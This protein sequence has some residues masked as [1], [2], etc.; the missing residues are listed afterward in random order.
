MAAEKTLEMNEH[1]MRRVRLYVIV[2]AATLVLLLWGRDLLTAAQRLKDREQIDVAKSLAG[3]VVTA[4]G[5]IVLVLLNLGR[6]WD[7]HNL[8]DR[9]IFGIRDKTDRVI[10]TQMI[11]AAQDVGAPALQRMESDPKGVRYVFYHF[12]NEQETLRALAFTYWEQY[13]V[14]LYNIVLCGLGLVISATVAV[15][16]Q[17]SWLGFA[18]PTIFLLVGAFTLLSTFRSLAH[19]IYDLPVQQVAEIRHSKQDE[20]VQE[21]E[22]RFGFR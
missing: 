3:P 10:Q 19:K 6:D 17:F 8:L 11:G 4:L 16:R 20:F 1:I 22:C 5:A 15:A 9:W 12:V 7:L 13:F 21:I 18:A 14:N 2:Y